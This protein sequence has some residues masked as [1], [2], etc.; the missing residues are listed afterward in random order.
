MLS[1]SLPFQAAIV[2]RGDTVPAGWRCGVCVIQLA[3]LGLLYTSHD[4]RKGASLGTERSS[5]THR[6]GRDQGSLL[7][8][9]GRKQKRETSCME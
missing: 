4:Q 6:T 5:R 9:I 7:L 2:R 1:S 3:D 8:L